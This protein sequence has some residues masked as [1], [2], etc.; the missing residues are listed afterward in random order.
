MAPTRD[1]WLVLGNQLFCEKKTR[2][3]PACPVFMAESQ[4]LCTHFKYHKHKIILFLSSMRSYAEA[5]QERGLAVHYCRIEEDPESSF[6]DK[7]RG[8]LKKHPTDR[9][10]VFEIED[11]FF[12]KALSDFC[13]KHSIE[14]IVHASSFFLTPRSEFKSYLDEVNKP[15]MKTFYERQRR[16]LDILLEPN[17]KPAGGKWSLD[18]DNRSKLPKGIELPESPSS[19]KTAFTETVIAAVD[20]YFPDHP[21]KSSDFWLPT[22]RKGALEWMSRFFETCFEGFGPYE[23]A[24]ST[25]SPFVFH[26]VLSPLINLGLITPDEVVKA[27]LRPAKVPLNSKEGFIRQMIGWRE[28]I[29]GIYQNFSEQQDKAN[30]WGHERRLGKAWYNAT[31]GIFPLDHAIQT[32]NRYGYCHHIERL[33]V[34]GNLFLLCEVEP[35]QVHRWFM[36]L[37]VD[38]SDWVMGPNVYGMALFSDGGIFSTKPYICA[39]NY[40]LKMSDYPKGPWCEEVDALFWSFLEKHSEFFS[41]NPRLNMLVKTYSKKEASLRRKNQDLAEKVRLRLSA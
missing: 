37:F 33:M 23:D 8:Y 28:F 17:G 27:A 15:W 40:L 19:P 4:D 25:R 32:V 41:K 39:S 1:L 6:L 16:R 12:E 13:R 24:L 34:L 7:L 26:S 11:K 2:A 35:R 22:T 5:L 10:H 3:I 14:L 9:L 36:E 18:E 38:S 20:R 29:G 31:T 21:G 30:F